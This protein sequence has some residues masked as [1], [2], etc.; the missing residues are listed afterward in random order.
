MS[1]LLSMKNNIIKRTRKNLRTLVKA[2][3]DKKKESLQLQESRL[4]GISL[5]LV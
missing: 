2:H 3:L 5:K 4:H 1:C